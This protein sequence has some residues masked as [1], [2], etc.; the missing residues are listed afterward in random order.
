MAITGWG[1]FRPLSG[2]DGPLGPGIVCG[3]LSPSAQAGVG[4]RL[5]WSLDDALAAVAWATEDEG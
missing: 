1:N 5:G 4:L 2:G 3:K